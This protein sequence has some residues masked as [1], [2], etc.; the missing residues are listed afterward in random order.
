MSNTECILCAKIA[1]LSNFCIEHY[2]AIKALHLKGERACSGT[3]LQCNIC[4]KRAEWLITSGWSKIPLI[5]GIAKFNQAGL[6]RMITAQPTYLCDACLAPS[7]KLYE[8]E[9][10]TT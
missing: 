7:G 10:D 5:T 1:C 6:V 4:G 8:N 3:R 9:M 2:E